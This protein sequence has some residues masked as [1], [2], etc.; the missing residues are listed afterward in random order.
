[1]DFPPDDGWYSD[2]MI[3]GMSI[4]GVKA[5]L[6]RSRAISCGLEEHRSYLEIKHKLF[7]YYEGDSVSSAFKNDMLKELRK[8]RK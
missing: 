5:R 4:C 8:R 2:L 6:L 3:A 7:H 1:M